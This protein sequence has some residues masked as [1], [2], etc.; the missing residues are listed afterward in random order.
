[1]GDGCI[2]TS[3]SPTAASRALTARRT[4]ANRLLT[5]FLDG[6]D[7]RLTGLPALVGEA[8]AP[9]IA[10]G[11]A[12]VQEAI[13][14]VVRDFDFTAPERS[15]AELARGLALLR[16]VTG[17]EG[18]P[19]EVGFHLAVKERQFEDAIVA[20]AGVEVVAE[21]RAGSGTAGGAAG[22][23][24]RAGRGGGG[25]GAGGKRDDWPR[26]GGEDGGGGGGGRFSH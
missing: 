14:G 19:A 23:G 25:C 12:G 26:R 7:T 5:G 15:V 24:G 8:V 9:E 13:D 21:L 10:A 20:A 22:R 4:S 18:V 2:G 17:G 6:I 1:M 11:L 16:A 3:G